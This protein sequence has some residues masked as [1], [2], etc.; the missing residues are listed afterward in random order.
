MRLG[1]NNFVNDTRTLAIIYK[2][3]EWFF[4][5]QRGIINKYIIYFFF[6]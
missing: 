6:F 3:I 4:D 5:I 1:K 2:Y